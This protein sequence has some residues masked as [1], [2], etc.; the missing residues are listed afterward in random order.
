M[1]PAKIPLPIYCGATFRKSLWY[2]TGKPPVPVDLSGYTA[3]L[4]AREFLGSPDTLFELT[5]ENGGITLTDEG[6]ITLFLSPENTSA[7]R[8]HVGSAVYGLHL[9]AGDGTV[10]SFAEGSVVIHDGAIQ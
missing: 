8:P 2:R 9:I 3:V 10:L 4:Q 5:T 7:L 6:Q 1:R